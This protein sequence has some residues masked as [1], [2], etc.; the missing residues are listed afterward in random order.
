MLEMKHLHVEIH[1][2]QQE[3]EARQQATQAAKE[4]VAGKRIHEAFFIL[5]NMPLSP[6]VDHLREAVEA[7]NRVTPLQ[8]LIA[9]LRKD[10]T[11]RVVGR[12]PETLSSTPDKSELF[13]Y[14]VLYQQFNVI[15]FIEPVREQINLEHDAQVDDLLPVVSHAPFV[16]P[17]REYIYARGLHAGLKGDLLVAAHLLVPQIEHSVRYMLSQR[18]IVTSKFNDRDL[19]MEFDL[20]TTLTKY[21]AEL[22]AI[23]GNNIVFDLQGLLVEKFGSNLRNLVAHGLL[24]YH[25]FSSQVLYLWW[26]TLHLILP[27]SDVITPQEPGK[28]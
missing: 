25:D 10:N 1:S 14:A 5:A 15:T 23:L 11:G 28:S 22:A 2:T 16:P 20:N 18:G 8:H 12:K 19:Q 21:H 4:A 13:E 26:L 7:I 17:G 6:D 9:K 24:D 3:E 27:V